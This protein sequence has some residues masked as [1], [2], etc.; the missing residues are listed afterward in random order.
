MFMSWFLKA[1]TI[2]VLDS[3]DQFT[4]PG[5]YREMASILLRDR[6]LQIGAYTVSHLPTFQGF[7]NGQ[8]DAAWT[9]LVKEALA[10]KILRG[11]ASIFEIILGDKWKR[12]PSIV[13]FVEAV[14]RNVTVSNIS[15]YG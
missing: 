14:R 4:S 6:A 7:L 5:V 9:F 2:S 1:E 13:A 8:I 15:E 12:G 10:K 11:G 3:D